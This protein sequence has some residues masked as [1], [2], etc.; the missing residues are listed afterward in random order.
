[1]ANIREHCSWVH[2]DRP[3]ATAKAIDIVRMMVARVEEATSSPTITVPVTKRALVIGGGIAGIQAAL[4]IADAGH[5]VVLVER[6]P[7]SAAT[8]P[9]SRRPSPPSTA[10][11]AS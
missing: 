11:S 9:S 7:P 6:S 4:D 1:M 8:W 3:E 10:P 2:E 5:Q